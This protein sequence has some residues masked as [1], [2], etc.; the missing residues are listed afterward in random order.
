[1]LYLDLIGKNVNKKALIRKA[2]I[3]KGSNVILIKKLG[4]EKEM[5]TYKQYAHWYVGN[6]G[7]WF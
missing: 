4:N 6:W 1:M 5:G 3:G 7:H 2:L